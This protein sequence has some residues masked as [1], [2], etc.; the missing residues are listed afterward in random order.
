VGYRNFASTGKLLG[1]GL[2][3][4]VNKPW[5]FSKPNWLPAL[6]QQALAAT[7]SRV[8]LRRRAALGWPR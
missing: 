7:F 8:Y 6:V 3:F 2:R 5:N 4:W 1:A